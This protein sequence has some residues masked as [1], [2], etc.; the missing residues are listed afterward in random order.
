MTLKIEQL[1]AHFPTDHQLTMT[2]ADTVN[3]R[4]IKKKKKIVPSCKIKTKMKKNQKVHIN[5]DAPR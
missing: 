4:D 1:V 5:K 3:R 2:L